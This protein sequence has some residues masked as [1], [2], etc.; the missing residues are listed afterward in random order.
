MKSELGKYFLDVSKLVLGGAVLS[1]ILEIKNV[2]KL[3]IILI[4]LC[5]SLVFLLIGLYILKTKKK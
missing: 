3:V 1:T 4:G 2:D 5:S